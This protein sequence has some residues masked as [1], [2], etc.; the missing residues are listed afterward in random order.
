MPEFWPT[1]NALPVRSLQALRRME[2]L[3]AT[4]GRLNTSAVHVHP[5]QAVVEEAARSEVRDAATQP[6]PMRKQDQ[7]RASPASFTC[8]P[9]TQP[10]PMRKQDLLRASRASFTCTPPFLARTELTFSCPIGDKGSR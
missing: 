1:E 6:A 4:L 2:H 8:T 3:E 7:L 10:A 9:A 5:E